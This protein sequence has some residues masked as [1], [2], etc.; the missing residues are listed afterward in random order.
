MRSRAARENAAVNRPVGIRAVS[1]DVGGTL[2]RPWPSV[3]HVYAEV[4]RQHGVRQA[5]PELLDHRFRTAWARRDQPHHPREQWRDLVNEVF[6][7]LVHPP[8][9]ETFFPE[10]YDRF[11]QAAA[12]RVFDDVR[13]TLDSLKRRRIPL[14]VISNWDERLRPLLTALDLQTWFSSIVISYEI[15]AAKPSP[16]IF[17]EAA[18]QL[19]LPPRS[20]LHIGDSEQD[21]LE[22]ALAAGFMA[23]RIDRD[24][25]TRSDGLITSLEEVKQILGCATLAR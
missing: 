17:Q 14:A 6:A 18:R 12:W 3:G 11:S 4:A 19:G 20:I 24:R 16:V 23:L 22:G 5:T 15:G 10:L 8:P 7:G 25:T 21:D 2:I 1:F 13:T 9:S